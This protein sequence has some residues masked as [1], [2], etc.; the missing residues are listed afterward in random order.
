[1]AVMPRSCFVS[2]WRISHLGMKPVS[3]GKPP[4][5]RRIKGIRDEMIG[6]L[7]HEI[8]KV[9]IVVVLFIMKAR[10]VEDVMII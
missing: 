2:S 3:G 4:N 8:V 1:M 10:K 7:A 5:D 6:V 9:P